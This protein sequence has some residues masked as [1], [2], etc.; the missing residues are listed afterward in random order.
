MK[1]TQQ[2][3]WTNTVQWLSSLCSNFTASF[4]FHCSVDMKCMVSY[5][6]WYHEPFNGKTIHKNIF[7]FLKNIFRFCNTFADWRQQRQPL[8]HHAKGER[9]IKF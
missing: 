9:E 2:G 8:L 3:W 7:L 1:E 5:I 4:S 6:Q